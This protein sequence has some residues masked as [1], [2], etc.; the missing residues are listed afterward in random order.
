MV[1]FILLFFVMPS[2]DVFDARKP[3]MGID[4]IAARDPEVMKKIFVRE[5]SEEI[6]KYFQEAYA[7]LKPGETVDLVKVLGLFDPSA[8][9]ISP[10]TEAS[11]VFFSGMVEAIPMVL[12]RKIGSVK[13]QFS[14]EESPVAPAADTDYLLHVR[15]SL[16]PDA[17][18]E[19]V[20]EFRLQKIDR[21]PKDASGG[22]ISSVRKATQKLLGKPHI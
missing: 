13:M 2:P 7:S 9:K 17:P 3:H 6:G 4:K 12:Q 16:R 21:S 1:G 18:G 5:Y 10:A 22:I 20:T 11:K 15:K 8:K 14:F 19:I